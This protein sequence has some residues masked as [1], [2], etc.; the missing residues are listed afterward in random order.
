MSDSISAA[1]APTLC[2]LLGI[3]QRSGT[4]FLSSLLVLHPQIIGPGPIW[5]DFLL[6]ESDLLRDYV[7][8]VYGHW[9]SEWDIARKVGPQE[10]LL[11]SLGDALQGFLRLQG[12][13]REPGRM[14]LTKTPSVKG[15]RNF[16]ALFPEAKLIVLVRDGRAVVESGVRSFG[17]EYDN[18]ARQWAEAA[19]LILQCVHEHTVACERFLLVRYE[20]LVVDLRNQLLRVLS[21]LGLDNSVYPFEAAGKLQVIGSSDLVGK[22]G[23]VHWKGTAKDETFKPLERFSEWDAARHASFNRIAGPEMAELG[24]DIL[25]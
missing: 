2:F 21:F 17:W 14:R 13:L 20:D 9:N 24:Y 4:N 3:L 16:A 19:R 1:T 10:R 11:Q 15:L 25:R 22:E 8:K 7:D 23:V 5:E 6:H 12:S 18:A